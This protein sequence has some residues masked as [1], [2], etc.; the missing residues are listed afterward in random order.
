M[1]LD[2]T[3]MCGCW[4]EGKIPPPPFAAHLVMDEEHLTLAPPHDTDRRL[5]AALDAWIATGCPHPEMNAAAEHIGGWPAYRSFQQALDA[6]RFPTLR[7]ELPNS[8]G[9]T[10]APEAAR[11]ILDELSDFATL[12]PLGERFVLVD[13][14]TGEEIAQAVDAYGGIF[15]MN[16]VDGMEEG[17][18]ADG[19][20]VRPM[21]GGER[22]RSTDFTQ[23]LLD[24]EP[25]RRYRPRRVR[26]T[27]LPTG[28]TLECGSPVAGPPI[29]WPD[30]RW[31]N[32]EGRCGS[33]IHPASAP[34]AAPRSPPTSRT[35]SPPSS[36]SAAP[37]S[38]PATPSA[39]RRRAERWP[40]PPVPLSQ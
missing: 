22:F 8:N 33:A 3:V 38:R 11:R 28:R 25:I 5:L 34:P 16:G 31:Q 2:A 19:F 27:D 37:P 13:A 4:A 12:G 39:G 9:G 32:G 30:G 15:S 1:G 35:S 14:A 23:D 40:S 7:R 24:P 20:F 36:A 21:G 10:T 17:I 26:F 18:D 29:P 6:E